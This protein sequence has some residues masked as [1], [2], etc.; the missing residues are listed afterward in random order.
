MKNLFTN[1]KV[2]MDFMVLFL[3]QKVVCKSLCINPHKFVSVCEGFVRI[4]V[5]SKLL[6]I[7]G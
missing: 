6:C 5:R 3:K 2:S 7:N 4:F 1:V